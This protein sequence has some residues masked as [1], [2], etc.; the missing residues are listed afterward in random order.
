MRACGIAPRKLGDRGH[1]LGRLVERDLAAHRR[2]HGIERAA[3]ADDAG[4]R[5]ARRIPGGKALLQRQDDRIAERRPA[6][7][8]DAGSALATAGGA[9]PARSASPSARRRAG[10]ADQSSTA[11]R[12]SRR[13][14]EDEEHGCASC[15]TA[16]AAHSR[17]VA[18]IETCGQ[19]AW[20]AAAL[21]LPRLVARLGVV[22]RRIEA[23]QRHAALDL[24]H[25]PG[26]VALVLRAL[27]RRRSPRDPSGS[28]PR[29]RR[30]PRS[31]RRETPRRR[32]RRSA[33]ASRRR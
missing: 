2:H 27:A 17:Q 15:T 13:S 21:L 8:R 33:P 7:D 3:E 14:C 32:R 5:A 20:P 11:A 23:G 16:R 4:R 28:A 9:L 10:R 22:V 26:L 30:R 6:D 1:A 19:L 25:H 31:R 29:R 24:A 18:S 12:R